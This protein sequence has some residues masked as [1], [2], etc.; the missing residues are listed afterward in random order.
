[1]DKATTSAVLGTILGLAA[2]V[3]GMLLFGAPRDVGQVEEQQHRIATLEADRDDHDSE[4]QRLRDQ[5]EAAQ[6]KARAGEAFADELAAKTRAKGEAEDRANRLQDEVN[7]LKTKAAEQSRQD[8]ARIERLEGL[9]A[10]HGITEHLSDAELNERLSRLEATFNTAFRGKDKKASMEALWEIQKLGPRAYDKAIEIWL[11]LAG[12][13][14]LGDKFGNGPNELGMTFQE[15]TSLVREWGLVERGLTDAGVDDTFRI[16]AIYS[17]PWWSSED[18]DMRAKLV[19]TVLLGS[20]GYEGSAAVTALGQINSATSVRYLI[21]YLAQ[22]RDNPSARKQAITQLAAKNTPEAWAAIADAAAND[23]D[24]GV[25]KHAQGTLDVRAA[26][27]KNTIAGILVTA[28]DSNKQ[29]ALAGIQVND[30]ITHFNDVRV[31]TIEQLITERDKVPAGQGASL[32]LLRGTQEL[33]LNLGAGEI[34]ISGN[35]VKPA[36]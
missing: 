8:R 13:Y 33:K 15:Y 25:R 5:L 4:L 36:D 23:V 30:I 21:D 22:N 20:R 6:R 10:E 32:T 24:E 11:Q 31:Q 12:D 16:N 27:G 26:T 9:L 1:M 3:G 18:A 14:G 35:N 34:G 7:D 17:A 28:V 19:G 29:A 2:G